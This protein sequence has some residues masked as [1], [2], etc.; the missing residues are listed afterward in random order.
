MVILTKSYIIKKLT[1]ILLLLLL[2][3]PALGQSDSDSTA[4]GSKPSNSTT[5]LG[6]YYADKFV[7]RH[8]SNGEIFRQNQY[9]AAHKTIPMGTFL[10]VTYPVTDQTVVVRVNDRCPKPNILDMTKIAVHAL[11]IKG[12]GKVTVTTLDPAVGYM[13]WIN[14]DTLAMTTAEYM[15][16]WDRSKRRR[17]SP[18]PHAAKDSPD[19]PAETPQ[20]AQKT[21]AKP[22]SKKI[23]D[24]PADT[25]DTLLVKK[26]AATPPAQENVAAVE[27]APQGPL[28]DIELCTVGSQYAAW[29]ERKRLPEEMQDKL[30]LESNK[31]NK[32]VRIVL[33]LA[34]SRSHAVRTQAELIDLFPESCLIPHEK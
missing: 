16:Y 7:G 25:P 20:L 31:H 27:K 15:A 22:A 6:T 18:Y 32:E 23:A 17:I 33:V 13:L 11:G 26:E 3:F 5:M 21:N 29:L 10:L 9:T 19:Q 34:E 2:S 30:L 4:A 12:S 28:Y 1:Y 24:N 14:Q 8:T